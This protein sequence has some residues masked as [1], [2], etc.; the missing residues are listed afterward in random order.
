M[1]GVWHDVRSTLAQLSTRL[2]S[3]LFAAA[4]ALALLAATP[5]PHHA[6]PAPHH[7]TPLPRIDL[8]KVQPKALL[9]KTKLH[10]EW[11]VDTNKFGQ[12]TRVRSDRPS[13]NETFNIQTFGNASQAFIRTTNGKAVPGV[14]RLI[15]DYNP[16]TQRVRRD[17]ALVRAGGVNANAQGL[18]PKMMEEIKRAQAAKAKK[19]PARKPPPKP[20]ATHRP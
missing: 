15:Y 10:A 6:V 7:A 14:Y 17:V 20:T 11:L 12:V 13:G 5:P 8:T 9:P 16:K 2:R 3:A 19:A 18:V 1:R 4:G